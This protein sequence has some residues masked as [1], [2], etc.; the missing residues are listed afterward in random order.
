M[1]LPRT[2][3]YT[4]TQTR[5]ESIQDQFRFLMLYGGV[6][7]GKADKILDAI[8]EKAVEAV[9]IY[10]CNASG[11]RV[12]EVEL[13]VDWAVNS[14]LTLTYPTIFSGLPGW[15]DKE[16]PEIRVAGRRFATLVKQQGLKA[17]HWV[18]FTPSVRANEPGY[19]RWLK[20][21]NLSHGAVPE[22][23]KTPRE[24]SDILFDL[25][26]ANVFI[27]RAGE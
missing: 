2:F 18:L 4:W 8:G 11:L 23:D 24:R 6:P 25:S 15:T 14:K 12:A 9:G 13:R 7:E 10:G 19:A 16:T 22:W 21:L 27:R 3:T 17:S 1:T 20:R 26:E 5:L